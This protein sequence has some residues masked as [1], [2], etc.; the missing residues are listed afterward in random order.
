MFCCCKPLDRKVEK[1]RKVLW[2]FYF[3]VLLL[4]G[5]LT[6][7]F[8]SDTMVRSGILK[9]RGSIIDMDNLKNEDIDSVKDLITKAK[10][11]REDVDVLVADIQNFYSNDVPPTTAMPPEVLQA[12][13]DIDSAVTHGTDIM[14]SGI[15]DIGSVPISKVTT[16]IYKVETY[17]FYVQLG[18]LL[19][20]AVPFFLTGL[21]IFFKWR[22][23]LWNMTWICVLCG[24][25]AWIKSAIEVSACVATSDACITPSETL[26]HYAPKGTAKD[27]L[28]YFL[29]C[30][31]I[32]NPLQPE[33]DSA[34]NTFNT[35]HDKFDEIKQKT[36]ADLDSVQ[37]PNAHKDEIIRLRDLLGTEIDDVITELDSL[38]DSIFICNRVHN[39]YVDALDGMCNKVVSGMFGL[40]VVEA[41]LALMMW[42]AIFVAIQVY[43]YLNQQ[44][45]TGT[46]PQEIDLQ[47]IVG[48]KA[49]YPQQV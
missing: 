45:A 11:I 31:D 35:A 10:Q 6:Y 46:Q 14:Q 12:R 2:L 24:T 19:F 30:K 4:I 34:K 13:D 8:V 33:I 21:G 9:V 15:N 47:E 3:S 22:C 29:I 28:E 1:P 49:L 16:M 32:A 39:N 23:L 25:L 36:Q 17:R 18:I 26:I 43:R 41:F 40:M 37:D 44:L 20:I 27:F 7:G 38:I 48:A 42:I 5:T